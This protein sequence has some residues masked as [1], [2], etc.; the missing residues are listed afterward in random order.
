MM[1]QLWAGLLLLLAAMILIELGLFSRR[2]RLIT[3]T[4]ALASSLIWVVTAAGVALVIARVY[5]SNLLGLN[6]EA[7][8]SNPINNLPLTGAE[9]VVQFVTVY[10]TELAL[11][12]DNILVIAALIAFFKVPPLLVSRVLFWG[13]VV[14]LVLRLGLILG[15]G[16]LIE[17]YAWMVFVF[18]SLLL[19]SMLRTLLLPDKRTDF[20][21]RW[22][23]RLIRK[24]VPV[25][26]M[27]DGPKLFTRINGRLTVTP[28]LLIVAVMGV[29]DLTYAADSIP[30]AFSIT[31][32]P[33][34]AFAGNALAIL[35]LRALYF[36]I[37]NLVDRFRFLKLT[38]V[39]IMA[40]IAVTTII[41]HQ[42]K[43]AAEI[44]LAVVVS[45]LAVGVG[46]SAL[47]SIRAR[48]SATPAPSTTPEAAAPTPYEDIVDAAVVARRN[49]R[50]VLILIAGTAVVIFG[51]A[52]TP[53]PGPGPTVLVPIGVAILATE[54][55]WA[56][57]LFE[58]GKVLAENITA[59]SDRV[60]RRIPRWIAFPALILFYGFWTAVYFGFWTDFYFG[61]KP[62]FM[63]G[64]AIATA[65]GLSFPVLAW[66]YRLLTRRGQS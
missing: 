59:R 64:F 14:S 17:R 49:F 53:L 33:F 8:L 30:A 5:D 40:F 66:A 6:L 44:T 9:A 23:V 22:T 62:G 45:L 54:F 24:L 48:T 19:L 29:A 58:R 2:P 41:F 31:T 25:G 51:I 11:T 27:P 13:I 15:A 10:V 35:S 60:S 1:P 46:A 65:F 43:L 52:I 55:V 39:A 7:A 26:P 4:E 37:V 12:L 57:A 36:A 34:L 38:L 47:A 32:D 42:Q 56:R 18:A 20:S 21:R 28:L 3:P 61:L 50:K 63:R 16:A